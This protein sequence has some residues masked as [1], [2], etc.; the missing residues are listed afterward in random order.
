MQHF[1][2]IVYYGKLWHFCDDPIFVLTP[3][4]SCH[5]FLLTHQWC[6]TLDSYNVKFAN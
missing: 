2:M 6:E 4:G 1:P 5:L 3:S